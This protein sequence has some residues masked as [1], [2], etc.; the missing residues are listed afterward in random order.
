MFGP[1]MILC[2][3]IS[4]VLFHGVNGHLYPKIAAKSIQTLN[5]YK[6]QMDDEEN[7]C[8]PK[9]LRDRPECDVSNIHPFNNANQFFSIF[10]AP[11]C[12]KF[13]TD[14]AR[15]CGEDP[16]LITYFT[17]LCGF[18]ENNEFCYNLQESFANLD[19]DIEQTCIGS[20]VCP[21]A[22]QSELSQGVTELGCCLNAFVS[23]NSSIAENCNPDDLFDG[24]NVD[25]PEKCNNSP[26]SG[27]S[28]EAFSIALLTALS[29]IT[30]LG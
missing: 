27:I 14:V 23:Y 30:L 10:C 6:R 5:D 4:T 1:M 21:S 22:C 15:D 16:A 13:I 12:R 11:E 8:I 18:N 20:N 25:L 28:F 7:N 19:D 24:C 26:L 2:S 9:G 3:V 17:D 29:I